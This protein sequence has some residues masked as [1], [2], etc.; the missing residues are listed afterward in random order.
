M[1]YQPSLAPFTVRLFEYHLEESSRLG[2]VNDII[3]LHNKNNYRVDDN[4]IPL[5]GDILQ[6][7]RGVFV[8]QIENFL[9]TVEEELDPR[10]VDAWAYVTNC[11]WYK[12][13]NVHD[14]TWF[15]DWV[16]VYYLAVP[17]R[18]DIDNGSLVFCDQYMQELDRFQPKQGDF[19]IFP[20]QLKHGITKNQ[21]KQFRISLNFELKIKAIH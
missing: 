4:N 20:A 11:D 19:I 18:P 6:E 21:S 9:G 13:F 17:I 7:L 8:R 5:K 12:G 14:H 15:A 1:T 10:D 2:L 16:G 3:A